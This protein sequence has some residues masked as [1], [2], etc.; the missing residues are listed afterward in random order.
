MAGP[1]NEG[2]QWSHLIC[3]ALS[4]LA[5]AEVAIRKGCFNCCFWQTAARLFMGSSPPT[6]VPLAVGRREGNTA[7]L[8]KQDFSLS[9]SVDACIYL[10]CERKTG[11]CH[12]QRIVQQNFSHWYGWALERRLQIQYPTFTSISNIGIKKFGAK[13]KL[14]IVNSKFYIRMFYF[15]WASLGCF[16][17]SWFQ[18]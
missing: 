16:N 9:P 14:Q 7:T 17:C 3:M 5:H 4:F 15:C 6:L 18:I 11:S 12:F 13:F 1:R 2:S 10:T 8:F